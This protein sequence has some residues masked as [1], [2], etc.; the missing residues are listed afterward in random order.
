VP[1]GSGGTGVGTAQTPEQV[2]A[3]VLGSLLGFIGTPANVGVEQPSLEHFGVGTSGSSGNGAGALASGARGGPPPP[4]VW[5]LVGVLLIAFLAVGLARQHRRRLSRL[6]TVAAV[7]LIILVGGMTVAWAQGTWS[8]A[9]PAASP[10]TISVTKTG[11]HSTLATTPATPAG[12]VLFNRVLAFE[13]QISQAQ[14]G[15]QSPSSSGGGV[16]LVRAEHDLALSLEATLQQEYTFFATVARDQSQSS[17]L[18]QASAAQPQAVRNAVT[19]DVQAVQAQL[20]QQAAITQAAARN[21]TAFQPVPSVPAGP[22]AG[23]PALLWPMSGVITQGFG[24]S[25]IAI[26]P[27]LSLAG[28]SY[29]HF[30]T[31][32]DIAAPFAT[33]VLAAG[34]GVVALAG[35]ETD[36]F[37]HLVGYG[38]YV[39]IAHGG[40]MITLYGHLDRILVQP[41]QPVQAGVPIGLEGST[42]NSTGPHVHFELRVDGIPTD[43]RAYVA[44]A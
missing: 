34:N 25:Q 4:A 29:R 26:E 44:P 33:P 6:R 21:T 15:L 17:A 35:S 18:I 20:A 42:G 7:P 3:S 27:A 14:A 43:P 28:I 8:P 41:G 5:A 9:A 16:A 13:T 19:Y 22:S 38:N 10:A 23:T 24:P 12:S 30:H 39:V 1:G 36:G 31:G 11:S 37:G 2:Q 40:G 32:I